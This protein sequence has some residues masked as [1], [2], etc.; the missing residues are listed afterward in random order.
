LATGCSRRLLS[1]I[2]G[3]GLADGGIAVVDLNR[4]SQTKEMAV[5]EES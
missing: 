1:I 5:S 4:L 3:Y 2:P